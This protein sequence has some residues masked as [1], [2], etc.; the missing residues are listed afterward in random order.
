MTTSPDGGESDA[1]T[2][3][4]SSHR[5]RPSVSAQQD[6]HLRRKVAALNA[7]MNFAGFI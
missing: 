5:P 2:R 3:I 6:D 7:D 4:G 1:L